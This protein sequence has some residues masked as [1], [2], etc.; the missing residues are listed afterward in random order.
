[1]KG[2][3]IIT[4][5]L[6]SAVA[7][8]WGQADKIVRVG[9]GNSFRPYSFVDENNQVTGYDVEVLKEINKRLPGYKFVIEASEFSALL[10]GVETGKLDLVAHEFAKNPDREKKFLFSDEPYNKTLLKLVVRK[11]RTDLNKFEDL[12]GKTTYQA[13]TSNFYKT[14]KDWND[15]N[16]TRLINLKAIDNQPIAEGFKQVED[17]REDATAAFPFQFNQV[18]KELNLNLKLT[19]TVWKGD[20]F[21]ILNKNATVL[22]A[23]IDEAIKAL[24]KDGTLAA[25]SNKWLGEDTFKD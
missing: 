18:Q 19:G 20:I 23:K 21:F 4:A 9:T 22:K 10:V 6:L 3:I 7:G 8:A 24:K 14:V 12:V 1:M 15:R 2:K 16:P 17:G 13:A 5:L 25:L 11:D